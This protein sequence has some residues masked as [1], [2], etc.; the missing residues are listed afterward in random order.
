MFFDVAGFSV[1]DLPGLG[2]THR[3]FTSLG[4]SGA[5]LHRDFIGSFRFPGFCPCIWAFLSPGFFG[6][7][8]PPKRSSRQYQS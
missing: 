8:G 4:S 6:E 2:A 5:A 7:F 1:R 3:N